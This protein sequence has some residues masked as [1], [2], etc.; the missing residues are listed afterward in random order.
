M[1]SYASALS[2][3]FENLTKR[4]KYWVGL[5]FPQ[6]APVEVQDIPAK[7]Y[8]IAPEPPMPYSMYSIEDLVVANGGYGTLTYGDFKVVVGERKSFGVMGQGTGANKGY[9]YPVE[10]TSETAKCTPKHIAISVYPIGPKSY[11]S[12]GGLTLTVGAE[13]ASQHTLVVDE[14]N[15]QPPLRQTT[16]RDIQSLFRQYDQD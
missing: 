2:A 7:A 16:D 4:G 5:N 9:M 10:D 8:P 11:T 14:I 13:A 15:A 3:Y 1:K 12:T 6:E